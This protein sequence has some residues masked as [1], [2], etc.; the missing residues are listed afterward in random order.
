MENQLNK[1]HNLLSKSDL[2]LFQSLFGNELIRLGF[3]SSKDKSYEYSYLREVFR[4]WNLTEINR[5]KDKLERF[6]LQSE[7][8]IIIITSYDDGEIEYDND[9]TYPA[10]FNF[11]VES[12]NK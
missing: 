6:N 5:I 10:S 9:R 2:E 12:K 4:Y 7:G 3:H 1:T 8:H 11:I